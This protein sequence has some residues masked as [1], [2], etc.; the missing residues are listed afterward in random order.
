MAV[1]HTTQDFFQLQKDIKDNKPLKLI[2]LVF[3]EEEYLQ[4]LIVDDFKNYFLQKKCNVNYETFYGENIDFIPLVNSLTTLPL[5]AEKQCIIIKQVDK[6]KV[7]QVKKL[8]SFLHSLPEKNENLLILL[9]CL[10]KKIPA[11]LSFDKVKQAGSMVHFQKPK[12]FQ[13]KQWINLKCR[14]NKKEISPEAV[15]YLQRLTDNDL[16]QIHNEMQKLFCYLGDDILRIEKEHVI[17]NVYGEEG[18]S[19][20]D[21][22]DAIGEKNAQAALLLLKKLEEN[23]Y[24]VLSLLA[25]ISRQLKLIFQ[26]KRGQTNQKKMKGESGLPPFVFNKIVKQSKKYNIDELKSAF[27]NLLDAEI[28]IKTGYFDPVVILEQLVLKITG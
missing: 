16:G 10:T 7:S 23:E 26:A 28:K 27:Q 12:S 17:T 8:N 1:K 15:Y 21:F 18:G 6:L 25:M 9:F 4:S 14:E 19:I 22:V 5:G 13:T 20:F 2:Y 24:H 3:G 11:N